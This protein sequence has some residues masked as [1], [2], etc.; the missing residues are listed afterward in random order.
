MKNENDFQ[1]IGIHMN[2]HTPFMLDILR[3][4]CAHC[5]GYVS[6]FESLQL[7]CKDLYNSLHINHYGL[8][9]PKKGT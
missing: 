7:N 5:E 6:F 2:Y 3:H 1:G 8:R 9:A 4:G